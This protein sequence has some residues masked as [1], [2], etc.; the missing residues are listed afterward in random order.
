MHVW[1]FF[2]ALL[3]F[4]GW[5]SV[6]KD[7]RKHSKREFDISCIEARVKR[8][9]LRLSYSPASTLRVICFTL[10]NSSKFHATFSPHVFVLPCFALLKFS[11]E[12][13]SEYPGMYRAIRVTSGKTREEKILVNLPARFSYFVLSTFHLPMV[14]CAF[15]FSAVIP[16]HESSMTLFLRLVSVHLTKLLHSGSLQAWKQIK[17]R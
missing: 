14:T 5:N 2:A 4:S 12:I 3:L 16:E 8:I 6:L 7:P 17:G 13:S 9:S 15:F 10:R 1:H 11:E